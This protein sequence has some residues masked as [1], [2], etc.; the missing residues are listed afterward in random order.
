MSSERAQI[1]EAARQAV[2]LMGEVANW[3]LRDTYENVVGKKPPREWSWDRTARELF[4]EFDRLRFAP[5]YELFDRGQAAE[6]AGKLDD[7]VEAW[8]QVL[9]QNP[10]FERGPEMVAGYFSYAKNHLD[11]KPALATRALERVERLSGESDPL[12][13]SGESLRLTLEA[14]SLYARHLADQT[15][16]RRAL[17]L[18]PKNAR[19]KTL[20]ERVTRGE[21][22]VER[23]FYRYI[24]AGAILA[25]SL[26][27]LVFL[28]LRRK[29][30]PTP[31]SDVTTS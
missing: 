24:A 7:M 16:L 12:R 23:R 30:P 10:T 5:V 4:A 17:D 18:D 2:V 22:D 13:Q 14:E 20:L 21:A 3:Q 15:L 28:L 9:A 1:R 27:A 26:G 6:R 31:S 11:D 19:A 29:P 8:D 25:L